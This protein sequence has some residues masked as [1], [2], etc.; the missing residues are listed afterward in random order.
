MMVSFG[1]QQFEFG[2]ASNLLDAL[3]DTDIP[4]GCLK[5]VCRVCKC[6]LLE[7][8]VLVDGQKI[9]APGEILP[10]V[11]SPNSN[12][13]LKAAELKLAKA[14]VLHIE[15]IDDKVLE[16]R[17]IPK[18]SQF[19]NSKS[20]INIKHPERNEMRSYSLV[21]LPK[22]SFNQLIFHVKLQP[23]GLFS[24]WF[25]CLQ[26]GEMVSFKIVTDS[27]PVY[28][29]PKRLVTVVAGGS[30][31]GAA[32]SRGMDLVKKL[33]VPACNVYAINRTELSQYHQYCLE[34]FNERLPGSFQVFNVKFSDWI[35]GGA[36]ISADPQSVLV[37][38]GS[39]Q[40]MDVV[41]SQ[42]LECATEI[43]SFG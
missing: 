9:I 42:H 4:R 26:M 25:K 5:G 15:A 22:A 24:S 2:D 17:L 18:K 7:G 32:L 27:L 29:Q 14:T 35:S 20:I 37:A 12:V 8:E 39:Q 31:M 21:S 34:E 41:A 11:S 40:V 3:R 13:R 38:V 30:G 28:Q 16:I 19:F 10:C 23:D 1:E 6:Q 33:Q 43:E 36:S